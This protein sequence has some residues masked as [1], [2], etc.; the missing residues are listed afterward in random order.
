MLSTIRTCD[1]CDFVISTWLVAFEGVNEA[2]AVDDSNTCEHGCSL[3]LTHVSSCSEG[4][5]YLFMEFY[6]G[7]FFLVGGGK[8]GA[9]SVPSVSRKS[10]GFSR[11]AQ[12]KCLFD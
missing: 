11:K 2:L 9:S 12:V 1:K 3:A 7:S 10:T 5:D 6:T 4:H 8:W